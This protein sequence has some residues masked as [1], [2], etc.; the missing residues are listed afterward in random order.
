MCRE[1]N[2]K[3]EG[4]KKTKKREKILKQR[5]FYICLLVCENAALFE[6]VV[7]E[8]PPYCYIYIIYI[9]KYIYI[10]EVNKKKNQFSVRTRTSVH[11]RI[12]LLF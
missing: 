3:R 4:K 10:K 7:S 9:Y 1:R 12:T 8:F 5:S 11:I 2:E 6:Q